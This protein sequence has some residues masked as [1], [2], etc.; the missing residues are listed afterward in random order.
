MNFMKWSPFSSRVRMLERQYGDTTDHH[1][2]IPS[3]LSTQVRIIQDHRAGFQ[4]H[5]LIIRLRWDD[6]LDQC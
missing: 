6:F 4:E 1:V 2:R 3:I 5:Q